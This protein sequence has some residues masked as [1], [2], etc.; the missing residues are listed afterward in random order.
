M[1]IKKKSIDDE[2]KE[3]KTTE[4]E[5]TPKN[6]VNHRNRQIPQKTPLT[7]KQKER[8]SE[9]QQQDPNIYPLF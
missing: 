9:I 5:E 1:D 8:L 2:K 3:D 6:K 4:N 7:K